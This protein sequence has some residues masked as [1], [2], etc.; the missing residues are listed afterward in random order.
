MASRIAFSR[1]RSL[2]LA[3]RI[4]LAIIG[5]ATFENPDGWPGFEASSW[6]RRLLL[7]LIGI[8][9]TASQELGDESDSGANRDRFR[10][11]PFKRLDVLVP[12]C[13]IVRF[14]RVRGDLPPWAV[15]FDLRLSI[16]RYISIVAGSAPRSF[17]RRLWDGCETRPSAATVHP[18]VSLRRPR[19][20]FSSE[21]T[22]V[23]CLFGQSRPVAARD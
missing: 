11:L 8:G 5:A 14:G 7:D 21:S 15:D 18:C 9:E 20:L 23:A 12:A 13:R 1:R 16:Y 2:R 22:E 10:G 19:L 4:A 3:R 17:A 6:C